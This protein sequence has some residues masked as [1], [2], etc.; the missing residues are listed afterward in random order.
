M[1][2]APQEQ[3]GAPLHPAAPASRPPLEGTSFPS[4]PSLSALAAED[5][6]AVPRLSPVPKVCFAPQC[7]V[8]AAAPTGRAETQPSLFLVEVFV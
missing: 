7:G 4:Q 6:P 8:R 3:D 2:A 1:V 5:A